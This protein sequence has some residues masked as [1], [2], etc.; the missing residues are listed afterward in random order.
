MTFATSTVRA[1]VAQ[2]TAATRIVT[3]VFPRSNLSIRT[4]FIK[5]AV[6]SV[7]EEETTED[8]EKMAAILPSDKEY[9]R[10]NALE[11]YKKRIP[12]LL[13]LMVSATF[14]GM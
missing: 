10:S 8:I 9:L 5:Q 7:I 1:I 4:I 3:S 11:L 13:L 6:A 12:W 2:T 14:T